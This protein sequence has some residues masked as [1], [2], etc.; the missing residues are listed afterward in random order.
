MLKNIFLGLSITLAFLVGCTPDRDNL[1]N[2]GNTPPA[3]TFTVDSLP[4]DGNT[5]IVKDL[6]EGNY[7]RLWSFEK[8]IP[9]TS[10]KAIDTIFFATAGEYYVTLY[11]SK[12][13]GS[14]TVSAF[15]K[16][17]VQKNAVPTCTAKYALL[18]GDCT[19]GGKCWTM[20]RRVGA[21]KAGPT[22]DDYS[23]F[24]S[25]INGLQATQYDDKFC[26]QFDGLVFQ[27][28]NNGASVNPWNGYMPESYSPGV[29]E[30]RYQIGT[31]LNNRDQIVIPN[32]QF[33]GV[34]DAD[35][36][37]DV[38]K[39]TEL[40]LIVRCRIRAQNGTPNPEGWLELT[41]EKD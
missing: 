21:V 39:L 3:P 40:E 25:V 8:G 16:I 1:N 18:T 33:M 38:V 4:T 35:N 23:W 37:I 17:T 15:K 5:F 31:G 26:F 41:F 24:T 11:V 20:S 27:N 6:S 29:S 19:A 13:D 14:G 7:L 12:A 30:F 34:W 9:L 36:V 10:A 28:K 32:E 2:L 22:Y